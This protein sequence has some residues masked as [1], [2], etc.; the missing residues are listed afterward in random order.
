MIAEY[1]SWNGLHNKKIF[2]MPGKLDYAEERRC[3]DKW[4]IM[5]KELKRM[6]VLELSIGVMVVTR[7]VLFVKIILVH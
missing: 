2:N 3:I 6:M 7:T 1:H 5:K 4:R